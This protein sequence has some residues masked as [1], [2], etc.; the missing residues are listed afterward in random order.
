MKVDITTGDKIAPQ[1]VEYSF[2]LLFENRSIRRI[3]RTTLLIGT[4][5][6]IVVKTTFIW[7]M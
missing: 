1:A 6:V 4:G 2:R 5:Q 3:G 7:T